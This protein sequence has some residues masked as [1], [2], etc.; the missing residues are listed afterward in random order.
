M[1]RK[2]DLLAMLLD[3][4]QEVDDLSLSVQELTDAVDKIRN[5]KK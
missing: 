4:A 3:L 2:S 1:V 5:K